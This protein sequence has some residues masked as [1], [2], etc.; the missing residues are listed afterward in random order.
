MGL[1]RNRRPL[2]NNSRLR[3]CDL[4][5]AWFIARMFSLEGASQGACSL[6][7]PGNDCFYVVA[8]N[9]VIALTLS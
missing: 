1:R 5:G 8:G 3:L 9:S 6:V 4:G 7:A 2:R